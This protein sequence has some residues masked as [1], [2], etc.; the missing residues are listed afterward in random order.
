MFDSLYPEQ[1]PIKDPAVVMSQEEGRVSLETESPL[2]NLLWRWLTDD[3]GM[4]IMRNPDDSERF[5][6]FDLYKHIARHAKSAVP[7]EEAL[8]ELFAGYSVKR[9]TIPDG[10]KIWEIP[11]Q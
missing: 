10:T 1:P 6:D 5:P 11:L 8:S 4:S 2:Y 7:R 9:E 3:E